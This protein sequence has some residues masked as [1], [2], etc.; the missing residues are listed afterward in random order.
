[1]Q[2]GPS[3]RH[4][5]QPRR[6]VDDK[7]IVVSVKNVDHRDPFLGTV[8]RTWGLAY[9]IHGRAGAFFEGSVDRAIP[10]SPKM[11]SFGAM[12]EVPTARH[13]A[14]QEG[15]CTWAD[16]QIENQRAG[17]GADLRKAACGEREI[18]FARGARFGEVFLRYASFRRA[19]A[20]G[21]GRR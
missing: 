12:V 14:T 13:N 20:V 2:I 18:V 6:L 15:F 16:T 4:C 7:Q 5:Q 8:A 21:E 1:M 10:M 11:R 17:D 9:P 3:P 19:R